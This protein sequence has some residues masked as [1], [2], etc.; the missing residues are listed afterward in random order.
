MIKGK[1][2]ELVARLKKA[3]EDKVPVIALGKSEKGETIADIFN[4]DSYWEV[5]DPQETIA[6]EP[7]NPTFSR[8]HA[9]TVDAKDAEYVPVKH[10]SSDTFQRPEFTGMYKEVQRFAKGKA[11]S[12]RG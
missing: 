3:L 12:N 10:N 7:E 11:K 6:E 8:P 5:L 9:P 2:Q 4:T 1:K